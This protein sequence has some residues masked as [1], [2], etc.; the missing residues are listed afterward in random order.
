MRNT[1][2]DVILS[3]LKDIRLAGES[4]WQALCPAHEDHSPSLSITLGDDGR[5]LLKCF[6]GCSFEEICRAAGINPAELRPPS[7]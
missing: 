7:A 4:K 2:I 5:V 1:N 3:R 6:A